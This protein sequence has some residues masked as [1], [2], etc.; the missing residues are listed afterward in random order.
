MVG[1]DAQSIYGFRGAQIGNILQ[2]QERYN[3][4][5]VVK[6]E[7]NYRSTPQI[8]EAANSIIAHNTRQI[9]KKVYS[10]SADG[11]PLYLFRAE[12]FMERSLP[13]ATRPITIAPMDQ[14]PLYQPADRPTPKA[15]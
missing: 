6:L 8:V 14:A 2:F 5:K 1:D 12:T 3:G 9:P 7:C 4:A 11:D 13:A 15:L 10:S